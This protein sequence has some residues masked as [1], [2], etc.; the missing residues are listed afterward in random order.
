MINI[1]DNILMITQLDE[2]DN[3]FENGNDPDLI[4]SS[5]EL[6]PGAISTLLCLRSEN[7]SHCMNANWAVISVGIFEHWNQ[8]L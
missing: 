5:R 2:H 6:E 1:P 4:I 8:W 7:R 3:V